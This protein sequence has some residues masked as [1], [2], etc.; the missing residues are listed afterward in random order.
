MR[1]LPAAAPVSSLEWIPQGWG[2]VSCFAETGV[3]RVVV[4][5]GLPTSD[6]DKF[7]CAAMGLELALRCGVPAPELLAFV[8][9][10]PALDHRILRVFRC[11]AGATPEVEE[12]SSDLFGQLGSVVRRL[13]TIAMPEFTSRVGVAGFGRWSEFLA[14]RWVPT[15]ARVARAE[16]D[17][18]LVARA[19]A[20]AD[21]LAA[22]VDDVA[23]PV[24]CHRDLYLDNV[25]VDDGG[26]LVALLDFDLVEAWD[27]LVEFFKLEWFVFEPNPAARTPFM[28]GYLAGDPLPPLFDE[29]A[30][31]AT[32]VELVNHAASWRLIGQHDIATEALARLEVL[33][34]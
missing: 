31:L 25:L 15:L 4:K 21:E 23:T 17:S 8:E 27:P 34:D 12:A 10:V 7:R 24:L 1:A 26:A 18:T 19:K 29:R 30:R 14:H 33:L 13:H 28:D 16:I 2:N 22:A 9:D 3:G 6:A 5:V 20:C 32:I 11:I